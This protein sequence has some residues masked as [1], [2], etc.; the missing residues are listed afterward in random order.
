VTKS[1]ARRRLDPARASASK[2]R[3]RQA[4]GGGTSRRGPASSEPGA[5]SGRAPKLAAIAVVV[6]GFMVAFAGRFWT[7]IPVVAAV[8]SAIATVLALA[9]RQDQGLTAALLVAAT[10]GTVAGGTSTGDGEA[11]PDGGAPRATGPVAPPGAP[12]PAAGSQQIRWVAPPGGDDLCLFAPSPE[13]G[14]R[15]VVSTC[16]R[17][18]G[19][20]WDVEDQQI[21]GPLGTCV[22]MGGDPGRDDAAVVVPPCGTADHHQTWEVHP[23][24]RQIRNA[25][26]DCLDV[27]HQ[28]GGSRG[29]GSLVRTSTCDGSR[30][31]RWRVS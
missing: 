3:K 31:Q 24:V 26:G 25:A 10:V 4:K 6:T 22:T 17:G 23:E 30:P 2:K 18:P 5:W 16:D 14:T 12:L 7:A 11:L 8:V 19:V 9:K 28:P 29:D 20:A 13:P 21:R 15:V 1:S 27:A